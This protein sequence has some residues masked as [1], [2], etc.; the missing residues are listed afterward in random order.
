MR[1]VA[2]EKK[3]AQREAGEQVR[4]K[5]DHDCEVLGVKECGYP[6]LLF[7]RSLLH[8]RPQPCRLFFSLSPASAIWLSVPAEGVPG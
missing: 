1:T 7:C 3:T 5:G 2:V 6:Q 8:L 4:E